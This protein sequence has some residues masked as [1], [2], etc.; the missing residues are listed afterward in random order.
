MEITSSFIV[1]RRRS[2]R[3][4]DSS[5]ELRPSTAVSRASLDD[6]HRRGGDVP[7][8]IEAGSG[9]EELGAA[10]AT[11]VGD[12]DAFDD[13]VESSAVLNTVSAPS[14][15]LYDPV[16]NESSGPERKPFITASMVS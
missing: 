11:E 16:G 5:V 7:V 12:L 1:I 10:I 4:C 14:S 13:P 3:E 8:R 2:R 15:M 9:D 6:H